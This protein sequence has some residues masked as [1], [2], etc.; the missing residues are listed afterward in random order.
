MTD[1]GR[2]LAIFLEEGRDLSAK[3]E[4]ALL[5]LEAD[6]G[7][8]DALENAL[9][10]AHTLKGSSRMVGLVK[11][12]GAA[13]RIEDEL[14]RIEAD[15]IG[16]DRARINGF[17][18]LLDRLATAFDIVA[19]GG[20][21]PYIELPADFGEIPEGKGASAA[22]RRRLRARGEDAEL[23]EPKPLAA[24]EVRL[25]GAR[26]VGR[27]GVRLSSSRV[28]RFIR[29]VED[30]MVQ[31]WR[32]AVAAG[33]VADEAEG[34]GE[35]R[36]QGF[37]RLDE[38]IHRMERLLGELHEDALE[39]RMMPLST[40]FDNYP[41]PLREMARQLGKEVAV[42]V[43]GGDTELDRWVLERMEAPLTHILRNALDHGVELPEERQTLGKE[44]KGN[45]TL[46]AYN[47]PGVVVV[48]VEDDGRGINPELVRKSAVYKGFLTAEAARD[49]KE[50]ELYE[51]MCRPGFS[52][53]R[54][55]DEVSGRGVGL[56]VVKE[57]M[58]KVQGTLLITSRVGVF[59][60]FRLHLP[61]TLS[62]LR[63]LV[64]RV[65]EHHVVFPTIFVEKCV[66]ASVKE[67]AESGG[68][69]SHEGERLGVAG[70]RS[71]LGMEAAPPAD[72]V[73]VVVLRFRNRRMPFAV[74]HVEH[75]RE[76]VVKSLGAHLAD[77]P[78]VLGMTL[79]GEGRPAPIIDVPQLYERW[80]GIEF[81]C[82]L[83][84]MKKEEAL[85]VLLVDDAVTSRHVVGSLL[86]QMGCRVVQ[87]HDGMEGLRALD[88]NL[89]DL[90]VTDVDMPG[91][92]GIE[93]VRR[94]RASERHR[95][96]AVVMISAR[97]EER[98]KVR[99][100]EAGVNAYIPKDRLSGQVLRQ[101]LRNLFPEG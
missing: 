28:D 91:L 100:F 69:I 49:M 51:L 47:R 38:E 84:V 11:V 44:K 45:I 24:S 101:T 76:V 74:D 16:Y 66:K 58:E 18:E 26:S 93:M 60:R 35:G 12:S 70:L 25:P 86:E 64:V 72:D 22:R 71:F 30:L 83:P 53:R 48:E 52:T 13:H 29:I 62:V 56:D 61:Q 89:V 77:T 3:L 65:G 81:A 2:Y 40:L 15:T 8:G 43:E 36:R 96:V 21:E 87:A 31:K 37:Q 90:V 14:K 20:E 97:G 79:L 54:E 63:G 6:P 10:L 95:A 88:F 59:T 33:E 27:E 57:R 82:R 85:R 92:D 19:A 23:P 1:A 32:L 78:C 5:A 94:I 67:L 39:L 98:D 17:L 68:R 50:A 4:G 80:R 7:N 73:S 55:A 41:R 34:G 42:H 46:R 75:E 9:R 99:G